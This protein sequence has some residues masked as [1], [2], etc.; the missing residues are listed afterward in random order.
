MA[1]VAAKPEAMEAYK[2]QADQNQFT[3]R[4]VDWSKGAIGTTSG[5]NMMVHA[6]PTVATYASAASIR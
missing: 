1:S 6:S 2:N 4:G 3:H 5:L